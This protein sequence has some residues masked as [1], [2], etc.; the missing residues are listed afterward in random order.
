MQGIFLTHS[1]T[2]FF[3]AGP[4]SQSIPDLPDKLYFNQSDL[5]ISPS[6]PT[7]VEIPDRQPRLLGIWVVA[8]YLSS[9]F[10]AL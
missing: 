5:G 4:L 2:L 6:L 8:E 3:E 10:I 7:Q 9:G 1:S